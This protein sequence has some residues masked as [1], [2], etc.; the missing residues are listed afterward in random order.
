MRCNKTRLE[1]DERA[2][3]DNFWS[4]LSDNFQ[5]WHFCSVVFVA[6]Y[7]YTAGL[8]K[9]VVMSASPNWIGTSKSKKVVTTA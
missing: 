9:L 2:E 8:T 4:K 3:N 7:L 5:K 6:H 1:E